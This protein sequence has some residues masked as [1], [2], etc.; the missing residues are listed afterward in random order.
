MRSFTFDK[1]LDQ[2]GSAASRDRFHGLTAVRAYRSPSDD[3]QIL[4]EGHG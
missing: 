2:K 4:L 1:L 3:S